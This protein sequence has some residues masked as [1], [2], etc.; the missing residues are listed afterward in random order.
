[1][2]YFFSSFIFLLVEQV[3][4]RKEG[5]HKVQGSNVHFSAPFIE[6]F[7]HKCEI[8]VVLRN[9]S[10]S[11]IRLKESRLTWDPHLADSFHDDL[12]R[13][14][15]ADFI[16]ANPPFNLKAWGG[17]RLRD[18]VR[19]EYGVPPV[20]NANLAW[21]QHMVHH[22]SPN[23]VTGFHDRTCMAV[24]QSFKGSRFISWQLFCL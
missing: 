8:H 10:N 12:H 18:D 17:E 7:L 22:L 15:K 24:D 16:P 6:I 14:V 23:A 5:F 3:V 9:S 11:S 20:G 4:H 13:D 19:W 21:A 2:R 1:M